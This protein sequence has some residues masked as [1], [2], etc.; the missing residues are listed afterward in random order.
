MGRSFMIGVACLASLAASTGASTEIEE[1]PPS[2]R[3]VFERNLV[4]ENVAWK[5]IVT[6]QKAYSTLLQHSR[7]FSGNVLA[8]VTPWN[9]HGYDVAKIFGSK[10]THVSPVWLQLKLE[11][12]S[13]VISGQHDVDRGWIREVRDTGAKMLPRVLFEGWSPQQILDVSSS[14]GRTSSLGKV[15][16]K[17]AHEN[18]FDGY[19]F[20]LWSQYNYSGKLANALIKIIRGLYEPLRSSELALILV[21]PPPLYDD[22]VQGMFSRSHFE[23]LRDHVTAFSL[24]TYDY[25]SPQRPG[26]NSPIQWV[27]KCVESLQPTESEYRAKILIGLNFYGYDYTAV[28]GGAIVGNQFVEMLQKHKPKIAWNEEFAEHYVQIRG[29]EGHHVMFFPT[30]K[31]ISMR[32]ALATELGCGISIWEVGQGM[33]YFYDLL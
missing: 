25:S 8:Y 20:E 26:P 11:G 21:I 4:S 28:G 22:N 13:F 2:E 9:N 23:Q 6:H 5:D 29:N 19:V 15:L 7:N 18:D 33:D 17:L 1:L 3:S 24:M 10:F 16:T 30:L 12:S 31:A 27:R 14:A 32:L